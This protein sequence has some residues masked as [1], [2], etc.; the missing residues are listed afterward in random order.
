[1][2]EEAAS[3]GEWE[4]SPVQMGSGVDLYGIQGIMLE[5]DSG[6]QEILKPRIR[7][8]FG[9]YELHQAATYIDSLTHKLRQ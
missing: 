9:S 2:G 4:G 1:M 8:E 5:F 7:K 6:S 3:G